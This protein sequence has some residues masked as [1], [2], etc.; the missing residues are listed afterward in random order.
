M[1]GWIWCSCDS[2]CPSLSLQL[3]L[4]R[5]VWPTFL[6]K[7]FWWAEWGG[8]CQRVYGNSSDMVAAAVCRRQDLPLWEK[9][10]TGGPLLWCAGTHWSISE[11]AIQ[12][13]IP[14]SRLSESFNAR[15]SHCSPPLKWKFCEKSHFCGSPF[16]ETVGNHARGVIC[17]K[18]MTLA[19]C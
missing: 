9:R 12:E 17:L 10:G 13:H 18:L 6:R 1:S 19:L 14:Q 8:V 16:T 4:R 2:V 7:P 5:S 11:R 3:T 15:P